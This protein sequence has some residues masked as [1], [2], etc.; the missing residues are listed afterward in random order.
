MPNNFYKK[1]ES[2]IDGYL[3]SSVEISEGVKFS[4]H[5]LIRRIY[6]FKNKTYPQ[7]KVDKQGGY[8]FWYDII[9]PRMNSEVKNLS[10]DTKN[11]LIFSQNP[12]KDFG[13]VL[14]TNMFLKDYLWKTGKAEE[15]NDA[16]ESFSGDGNFLMKKI[17]KGYETCDSL[18]TYI[19]NQT[20][21]TVDDTAIVERFLLTQSEL[22]EKSGVWQNIE[23]VITNCGN[24]Q[25]S[26]TK[27]TTAKETQ[28]PYYEIFERN[29]EL[30]EEELFS[31]KGEKGG[32]K[33][34]YI[35]CRVIV[36]GL[37]TKQG[38]DEGKYVLFADE[39]K[40]KKMSDVFIEAHRGAYN[41]RWWREGMYEILFDDQIR[42]NEIGNQLSRGLKWA[43]KSIFRS[44]DNKTIQNVLTDLDNGGIVDSKDLSQ[45]GVRMQGLDQLV[46]DWNRVIQ[47]ADRAAN[48]FEIV[49]GEEMKGNVPFRLG[50]LMDTNANKFFYFLRQ[51]LGIAYNKVFK[52]WVLPELIKEMKGKDIIRIT[53]DSA[54]IDMFRKMAVD[55]WYVKNLVKIG[56]HTK[57][58]ADVL[59]EAK[60]EELAKVD[61]YAK[62]VKDVWEKILPRLWISI[63]GENTDFE[64]EF[65]TISSL[66]QFE[67]DPIR[68][69]YLLDRVY[70]M[71]G[72][73]VPPPVQQDVPQV[74]STGTG[75]GKGKQLNEKK[76][77]SEFETVQ[78]T[79]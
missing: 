35:L 16:T 55:N 53:G 48:S 54:F 49:T 3:N 40:G 41:G 67:T 66:L 47:H 14:M 64:D 10:I 2:E 22:R 37:I 23:E 75:A 36:A 76:G 69:A 8:K 43:S 71:K 46:A 63:T 61:P 79:P 9:G 52:D 65:Q 15:F 6:L 21:K 59:K 18:N 32:R 42:G 77:V 12:I 60:F 70:A 5:K 27:K 78:T 20:A 68:R 45:V 13:A 50:L 39:L 38:N 34:R 1:I 26:V 19:I 29:G 11:P 51:K 73:P 17:K 31:L 57:E 4:Q 56:P 58:M 25:F 30:T 7:G 24:K 72:L 44:S 62:N 33:D 74:N 28:N